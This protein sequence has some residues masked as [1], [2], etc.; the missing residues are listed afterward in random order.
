ME[1]TRTKV[2]CLHA[3]LDELERMR[4]WSFTDDGTTYVEALR[5]KDLERQVALDLH[6]EE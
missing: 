6:R 1:G 2:E 5:R 3:V 4:L